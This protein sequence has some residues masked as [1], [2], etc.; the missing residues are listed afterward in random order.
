MRRIVFIVLAVLASGVS[1]QEDP[2][3]SV[4]VAEAERKQVVDR[5]EA[6]GTLRANESVTLTANVTEAVTAIH[7]DDGDRVAKGDV[8]VEMTSAEEHALLA[9]AQATVEEAKSQF[10]RNVKL[11]QQDSV[12]E[13]VLDTARREW[14][15]AKARL[16]AIQ[17]QLDDRLINAPFSG[18]VGLRDISPG[19]LVQPGDVITTLDDDSVMKLD[20]SVPATFLSA[21]RAGVEIVATSDAFGDEE[22]KGEVSAIDSRI[23]PITRTV[24]VRAMVPNPDGLLRPGLL[25]QVDLLNNPRQAVVIPEEALVPLGEQQFVLV[26]DRAD[27]NLV[28]RREVRIG[29]RMPG[30]VEI[31]AGLEAGE[32]IIT[33][34]TAKAR[35]GQTVQ[36]QA[37]DDGTQRLSEMIDGQSAADAP[38]RSGP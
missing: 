22:F 1:A 24:Q 21:L 16:V 6:L 25:M 5:I 9:E 27:G 29:R 14:E 28:E 38:V 37:V 26:V 12:S 31:I 15:T 35:A 20:F 19:A 2:P 36:I 4:I 7:F 17:S 33:H 3:P 18:L 30:E 34:G 32:A 23:D 10:D 11:S 13:S 8:L